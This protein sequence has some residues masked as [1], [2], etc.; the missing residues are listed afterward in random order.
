MLARGAVHNP[1]I[2][3][4]IKNQINK[5]NEISINTNPNISYNNSI[6][7]L[8]LKEE[9]DID[10]SKT[11]I[12]NLQDKLINDYEELDQSK[13][14]EL[15]LSSDICEVKNNNQKEKSNSV[16]DDNVKESKN[17]AKIF[18]RKYKG[19]KINILPVVKEFIEL[20]EKYE[21]PFHNTK[22]NS[23]YILKTH[24]KEMSYFNAIQKSKTYDDLNKIF[25]E[26]S[27]N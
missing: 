6:D 5:N 16:Y 19:N 11:N 7:S 15:K 13:D 21:N 23:S 18:Q 2:F 10:K 27:H 20:A 1:E 14:K 22:Y 26:I 12:L 17:L 4:L 9:N 24:K 8:M 3:E 25:S